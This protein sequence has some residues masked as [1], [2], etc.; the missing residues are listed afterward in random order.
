MVDQ[1]PDTEH[2]TTNVKGYEHKHLKIKLRQKILRCL[3]N[4]LSAIGVVSLLV[5]RPHQKGRPINPFRPS[6]IV[7]NNRGGLLVRGPGPRRSTTGTIPSCIRNRRKKF[8]G[9]RSEEWSVRDGARGEV[10]EEKRGGS[11]GRGTAEAGE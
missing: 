4:L 8:G 3:S 1:I 2:G 11:D 10:G 6:I 5:R 9:V 7:Y